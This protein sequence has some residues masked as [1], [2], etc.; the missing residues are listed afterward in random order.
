MARKC[1][2]VAWALSHATSF[3][4]V[5]QGGTGQ[6]LRDGTGSREAVSH[7]AAG[8]VVNHEGL[9]G[10]AGV[11]TPEGGV[12]RKVSFFSED[13]SSAHICVQ[14]YTPMATAVAARRLA[15]HACVNT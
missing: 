3:H 15:V 4:L 8:V 13:F 1:F 7:D 9:T 14:I 2:R 5:S 6:E 11:V 10:D 12:E